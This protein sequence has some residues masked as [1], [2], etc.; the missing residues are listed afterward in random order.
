MNILLIIDIRLE[1]QFTHKTHIMLHHYLHKLLKRS[2]CRVPPKKS[3]RFSRITKKLFNLRRAEIFR[4]H[5]YNYTSAISINTFLVNTFTLPAQSDTRLSK[6]ESTEFAHRMHL[7]RSNNKIFR[8]AVLQH[9]PH[10]LNIIPCVSPVALSIKITQ[11]QLI[12]HT[13]CNTSSSNS[14][15]AGHECFAPSL[16]LM[17]K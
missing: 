12:L 2:L 6:C 7:T 1:L 17:I 13:L 14:N 8:F 5:L 4:I 15:F 10:T 3:A 11:I 16:T 9:Q